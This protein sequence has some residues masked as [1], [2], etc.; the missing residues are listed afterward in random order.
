MGKR[1]KQEPQVKRYPR[2]ILAMGRGLSG[3]ISRS[4]M[5]HVTEEFTRGNVFKIEHEG[6]QPDARVFALVDPGTYWFN[7]WDFSQG[8]EP[9]KWEEI[10]R[11]DVYAVASIDRI[12]IR[13]AVENWGMV[14]VNGEDPATYV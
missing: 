12:M 1:R 10:A 8:G 11:V 13:Y 6:T 5:V 3:D 9:S 7:N 2:G 4:L 14:E